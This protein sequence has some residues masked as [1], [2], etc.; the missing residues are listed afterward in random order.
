MTR[1]TS[2]RPLLAYFALAFG[3]TWIWHVV[4]LGLLDL[5]FLG[6]VGAIG[7][8]GPTL[9]AVVVTAATGGRRGVLDLLRSLVRWRVRPVWYLVAVLGLPAAF[10]LAA[11]VDRPD[12]SA[13]FQAPTFP[14][15]LGS[16]ALYLLVLGSGGP[17]G[18]EPGWRGFALPRLQERFGPLPGTLVLGVVHGL[19]H[20][21]VYVL[22]PGYNGATGRP[23]DIA[24]SFGTFV[25]GTT[26]LAVV[27]TWVVNNTG[28][29]LLLAVL[30]HCSVN[31]AG[32]FL[33]LFPGI[34]AAGSGLPRT[35]ALVV[36]ALAV[37]AA[38]RR[39]LGA[40][41]PAST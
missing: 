29:S 22:V 15:V 32:M 33:G 39:R 26:A 1:H 30:L 18:E 41:M 12:A 31:T 19:W 3:L 36:I 25:V 17:L 7:S 37:I 27:F 8:F 10:V 5:P 9:A 35:A 11:L 28:G 40:R 6:V 13:S 34:P 21:P 24:L 2:R 16:L 38:T 20:L 4:T 14:A 23:L